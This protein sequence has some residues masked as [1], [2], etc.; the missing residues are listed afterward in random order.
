[1]CLHPLDYDKKTPVSAVKG[2]IARN[3]IISEVN[4]K[5]NTVMY[6]GHTHVYK[7]DGAGWG[8]GGS[9]TKTKKKKK[10]RK[11]KRETE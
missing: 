6:S 5:D 4:V 2:T 3:Y 7:I 8:G 10:R 1:M 11:W 9:C